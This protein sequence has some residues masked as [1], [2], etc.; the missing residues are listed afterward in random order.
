MPFCKEGDS[1]S[2]NLLYLGQCQLDFPPVPCLILA[3]A[4]IA[5]QVDRLECRGLSQLGFERV[6][7]RDLIV[8]ELREA[9]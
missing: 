9:N 6:K 8:V 1:R 3:L 7:I 2:V 5:L 4:R